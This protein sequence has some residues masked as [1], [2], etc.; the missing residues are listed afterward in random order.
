MGSHKFTWLSQE[1]CTQ[2]TNLYTVLK[3]LTEVTHTHT[4]CVVIYNYMLSILD[5]NILVVLISSANL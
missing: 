1:S 3:T 2:V 5:Y 4:Y